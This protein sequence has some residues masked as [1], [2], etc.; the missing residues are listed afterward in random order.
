MVLAAWLM[1]PASLTL[2]LSEYLPFAVP[3]GTVT[4]PLEEIL[5]FLVAFAFLVFLLRA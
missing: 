4:T 2:I 5:N 1:S 3:L